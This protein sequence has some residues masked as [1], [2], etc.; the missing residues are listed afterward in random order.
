MGLPLALQVYTTPNGYN[1]QILTPGSWTQVGVDNGAAT[2]AGLD[3]PSVIPLQVPFLLFAGTYG[4][5]LVAPN[6][7]HR[8]TNGNGANQTYSNSCLQLNAGAA[9]GQVFAGGILTPRV[10]NGTLQAA[11]A[12]GTYA[13]FSASGPSGTTPLFVSFSDTSYTTTPG[14]VTSWAWDFNGDTIIDSNAQHPSFTYATCGYYDVTLTVGDGVT[15]PNTA[16]KR[17]FIAA[18]PQLLVE[19]SFTV[20]PSGTTPL[21]MAFFDTSTGMPSLWSWDFD[22][23]GIPDSA[24]QNPTWTTNCSSRRRATIS[25]SPASPRAGRSSLNR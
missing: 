18:D 9:T 19:A 3:L 13:D 20:A 11:V 10:F 12:Q 2:S 25:T 22:G 1:G 21:T 23:D 17:R 4:I 16:T 14:G 15:P 24:M 7:S 5:A 8:I 6:F